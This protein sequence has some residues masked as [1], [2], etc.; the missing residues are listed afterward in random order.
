[1]IGGN[2]QQGLPLTGRSKHACAA[3]PPISAEIAVAYPPR[4]PSGHSSPAQ[5]AEVA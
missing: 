5:L 1:M 4:L 2:G 3:A